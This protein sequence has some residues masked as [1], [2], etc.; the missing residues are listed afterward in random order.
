[1][2]KGF[3]LAELLGVI[4]LLALLASISY[5]ILIEQFEK[6]EKEI[7]QVKLDLIYSAAKNYAKLNLNGNKMCIFVNDLIDNDLIA[8]DVS[9]V[10]SIKTTPIVQLTLKD[11]KDY[12]SKLVSECSDSSSNTYKVLSDTIKEESTNHEIINNITY[13]F[14]NNILIKKEDQITFTNLNKAND[15]SY[16]NAVNNYILLA[17]TVNERLGMNS[18]YTKSSETSVVN[19]ITD[20]TEIGYNTTLS[21]EETAVFTN[22]NLLVMYPALT[23]YDTINS[24]IN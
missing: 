19:V 23:T 7:S 17:N 2:K 15:A 13:Y 4:L 9:E 21:V 8:I 20:Y 5:P 11:N 16:L 1:M 14:K 10:E 22:A 6:K 12:S 18:Y 3:T 24:A